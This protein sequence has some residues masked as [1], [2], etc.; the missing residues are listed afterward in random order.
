MGVIFDQG[1]NQSKSP[2]ISK[3]PP[4]IRRLVYTELFGFR[5]VHVRFRVPKTSISKYRRQGCPPDH[6]VPGWVHCVCRQ[7]V[8]A[9]PH[10]HDEANHKWCF[11][12]TNILF[13]CKYIFEEGIQVLYGSNVVS[14]QRLGDFK[15]F[16]KTTSRYE[17]LLKR[18]DFWLN[19]H[20]HLSR[21][22]HS[23]PVDYGDGLNQLCCQLSQRKH[24]LQFR[25]SL[26]TE[27]KEGR[28]RRFTTEL[29]K[30]YDRNDLYFAATHLRGCTK[31]KGL[32]FIPGQL[33]KANDQELQ[34]LKRNGVDFQLWDDS[35]CWV[36]HGE[37]SDDENH[38]IE[39][40]DYTTSG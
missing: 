4:E 27:Y 22:P 21:T 6:K 29:F 28:G 34:R 15:L 1:C 18:I 36:N 23:P 9:M 30:A 7:G 16:G 37:D 38:G 17:S 26:F 2:F 14:F 40:F 5:L 35:Y 13:T 8:E 19:P 32:F 12:A 25:I 31:L 3:L 11:L 20:H 39:Y 10:P 33:F 24:R